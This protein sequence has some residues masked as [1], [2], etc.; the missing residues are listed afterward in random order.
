MADSV[1]V[2]EASANS[3]G[4][5]SADDMQMKQEWACVSDEG[6]TSLI[7]MALVGAGVLPIQVR[8]DKAA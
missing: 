6:S 4:I 2:S 1:I 5:F 8:A 7:R 3:L